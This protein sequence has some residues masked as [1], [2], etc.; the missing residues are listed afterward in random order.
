MLVLV[1][2][3]VSTTSAAG[4]KRLRQVARACE[5]YGLRVQNSVFECQL[6]S[7]QY[8]KL[9]VE[10]QKIINLDL[11]SLRFYN[12]G[13]NYTNKTIHIGAKAVRDITDITIL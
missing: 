2:Y 6:D 10:L 12:L 9:Q 3:D 8:K 7:M 11:D 1:C 5:K 13:Q 4:K